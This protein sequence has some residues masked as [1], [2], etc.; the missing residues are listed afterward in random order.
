[1]TLES[2]TF[3]H[4]DAAVRAE[5]LVGSLSD[6]LGPARQW[7]ELIRLRANAS[8][9]SRSDL[10]A[11]MG[12]A[13]FIVQLLMGLSLELRQ[14]TPEEDPRQLSLAIYGHGRYWA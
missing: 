11:L 4:L 9:A 6:V 3:S 5:L 13:D 14:R 10:A 2:D 8:H 1:V 7:L 12:S